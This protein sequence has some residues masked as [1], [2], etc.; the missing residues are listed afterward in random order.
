MEVGI[1]GDAPVVK[2]IRTFLAQQ[3]Q[4]H[5][6]KS[7]GKLP[8]LNEGEVR[9]TAFLPRFNRKKAEFSKSPPIE[10]IGRRFGPLNGIKQFPRRRA[11]VSKGSRLEMRRVL[12]KEIRKRRFGNLLEILKTSNQA[13]RKKSKTFDRFAVILPVSGSVAVVVG[14]KNG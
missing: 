3:A 11:R 6:G 2:G 12:L 14:G 10:A 7:R 5:K 1:D 13:D 4:R 9:S 8:D